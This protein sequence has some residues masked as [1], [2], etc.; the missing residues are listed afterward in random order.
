MNRFPKLTPL[1]RHFFARR[2][3]LVAPALLG[4]LL[5]RRLDNGVVLMGRIVETEAYLGP[6]DPASHSIRRRSAAAQH[7]W[8]P[9][10]FAYVYLCMGMY[11]CLNVVV[12]PE[13]RGGCVLLRAVEP[14]TGL[15]TMRLHRPRARTD[16]ELCSGPGKLCQAFAITAKLNKA[17]MTA[18]DL[19]IAE[20]EKIQFALGVSPRIGI[21][22]A[23]DWPL[24]FYM[25]GNPYVSHPNKPQV[26][27]RAV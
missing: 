19:V 21:S 7:I 14:L 26:T 27:K 12:E 4:K 20:A 16:Y 5:V 17:D 15:E 11:Y 22:K 8:G 24:R 1:S 25:A 2:A 3:D 18:G 13:G 10:G 6:E 9:P 23:V